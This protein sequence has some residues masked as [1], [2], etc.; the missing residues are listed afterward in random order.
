[1]KRLMAL[2]LA[3]IIFVMAVGFSACG[4]EKAIDSDIK[5]EETAAER[6]ERYAQEYET[7]KRLAEEARQ[8]TKD[9]QNSIDEYNRLQGIINNSKRP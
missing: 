6:A 7:T 9:L 2:F 4:T 3:A 8:K 1:M 5:K